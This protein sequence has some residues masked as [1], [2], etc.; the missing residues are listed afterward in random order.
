MIL[1]KKKLIYNRRYTP[2]SL[3][4]QEKQEQSWVESRRT[5]K[6]LKME[7]EWK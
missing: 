4:I 3:N 1:K 6:W 2:R 7:K 5:S